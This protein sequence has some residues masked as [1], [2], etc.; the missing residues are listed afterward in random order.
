MILSMFVPGTP[1]PQGSK[2][3]YANG[4]RVRLVESSP[5]V[6]PWRAAIAAQCHEQ[7]VAGLRIDLP[8]SVSLRFGLLRPKG[9]YGKRGL[10]PSA[11]AFPVGKPDTDKLARSVLDALATDAGVILDD[12]R[13]VILKASKHYADAP[14]VLI[15][16]TEVKE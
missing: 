4:G 7:G 10:L 2:N 6:K 13:V 15:T 14:G 3:A 11:P 12:S 9:H 16:I 5:L 1:A 8:L